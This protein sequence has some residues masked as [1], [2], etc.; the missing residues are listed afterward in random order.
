MNILQNNPYRMLGVFANTSVKERVASLNK[1]KAYLMV[2]KTIS[3][4]LD[5][6][7]YLYSI[8]R[9]TDS[10][11]DANS[12]L[13]LPID[14]IRYAQFWFVKSTVEDEIAFNYLFSG[15]IEKAVEIWSKLDG[16]SS[17]QNRLI[18][19]LIKRNFQKALL[20]AEE[21]YGK[22]EKIK[23]F[24]TLILR[25]NSNI[26][27]S[28]E[29][30]FYFLDK[31]LDEMSA[32][33]MLKCISNSEWKN[34]IIDKVSKPL[35]DKIENAVSVSK[36]SLGQS[37][38]ESLKSGKLLQNDT[39]SELLQLNSLLSECDSKYQMIADK[40]ATNILECSIDYYNHTQDYDAPSKA[41]ELASY[42]M[43]IAVGKLVKHRCKINL[44]TFKQQ[45]DNQ[46]PVGISSDYTIIK[47]TIQKY[48][49]LPHIIFNAMLLLQQTKPYLE[50]IRASIGKWNKYYI[51][52][53]TQV[54]VTAM[55]FLVEDINATV[56][57]SDTRLIKNTLKNALKLLQVL[58]T[59]DMDKSYRLESYNINKASI[60]KLCGVNVASPILSYV[61]VLILIALTIFVGYMLD[62]G[63]G[64]YVVYASVISLLSFLYPSYERSNYDGWKFFE[65]ILSFS[66][67]FLIFILLVIPFII[68]YWMYKGIKFLISIF[69]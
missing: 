50:R 61:A 29:L 44:D 12:K 34:Y 16:V 3:F 42:A 31:I 59:F 55:N 15:N 2:G 28:K 9:T 38:S 33:Y 66:Y 56:N 22:S 45:I 17:L 27:S 11:L 58:D 67:I 35:I 54:V 8:D 49:Q 10:V 25:N 19:E 46:P 23:E 40:L 1:M 69:F 65:E 57:C 48:S 26:V 43:S 51:Y 60:E 41:F 30:V 4:P 14:Q 63:D 24:I 21:L 39:K 64:S 20:C 47:Q 52:I 7:Q 6:S 18:C 13:T 36:H 32:D 5:I 62:N 68:H 37:A 53:S